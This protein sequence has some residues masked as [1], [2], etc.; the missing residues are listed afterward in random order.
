MA[1]PIFPQG[2][3]TANQDQ[4]LKEWY[5][6]ERVMDLVYKKYPF[7][8]MLRK[9]MDVSGKAANV[10]QIYSDPQGTANTF[11][12]AQGNQYPLTAA[13]FRI[14][15]RQKYSLG[16]IT[17]RVMRQS[18]NE[19]GAFMDLLKE[20]IDKTLKT[21]MN[22]LE[23]DFV[24]NDG[25]G[26]LAQFSSYVADAAPPA[27]FVNTF[28]LQLTI[29]EQVRYWEVNSRV[30]V[31]NSKTGPFSALNSAV[32]TVY[33]V[34]RSEGKVYVAFDAALPGPVPDLQWLGFDG[35]FVT[36]VVSSGASPI[37]GLAG[38]LPS[39]AARAAGAL[40]SP[41]EGVARNTDEDRLAG[42]A[43]DIPGS[44]VKSALIRLAAAIDVNGGDPDVF[45]MHQFNFSALVESL[46]PNV[47]YDNIVLSKEANIGYRAIVLQTESGEV[48]IVQD[49]CVP[50]G[51]I[52]GLTMDS[53]EALVWGD[54]ANIVQ[55]DGLTVLRGGTDDSVTWRARSFCALSCN[56]VGY[57]GVVTI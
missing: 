26:A 36:N 41:F 33:R 53:W 52:Y 17:G 47:L 39:V 51:T 40:N 12:V 37:I 19:E 44:P 15:P 23:I 5:T 50:K 1:N 57:N 7:I 9:N 27:G 45:F 48:R 46:G 34:N 43:L 13:D 55:D 3:N 4:L 56:A 42:V 35:D 6:P 38:W 16:S 32:G 10:P 25:T 49:S 2:A 18:R 31:A 14:V 22:R 29:P 8:M 30:A 28:V 54:W 24:A 11:T 20:N 21:H